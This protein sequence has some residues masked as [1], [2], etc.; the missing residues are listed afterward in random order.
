LTTHVTEPASKSAQLD[1]T[2]VGDATSVAESVPAQITQIG[3]LDP[4]LFGLVRARP[5]NKRPRFLKIGFFGDTGQ[6]KTYLYGTIEECIPKYVKQPLHIEI[7]GGALTI[8]NRKLIDSV[9]VTT[10][11]EFNQLFDEIWMMVYGREKW[12]AWVQAQLAKGKKVWLAKEYDCFCFDHLTELDKLIMKDI[13]EQTV[14]ED[15][16]RDPLVPAPREWGKGSER[17]RDVVREMRNMPVHC[18][19]VFLQFEK[20]D[21]ITGEDKIRPNV[22]GKL[23]GEIPG[24]LDI[25]GHLSV[26]TKHPK[27]KGADGKERSVEVRERVMRFQPGGRYLAKDRSDKLGLLMRNPTMLKI[28]DPILGDESYVP[29]MEE[30]LD[31]DASES[32]AQEEAEA[33]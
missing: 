7:E 6:G 3:M 9:T 13:M 17:L 32:E 12:W 26:E 21:P 22:H 8:A 2:Q 15:S 24:F 28:M 33:V 1:S 5:A 25:L 23:A 31:Y 14:K 27:V 10:W 16:K 30:P 11:K 19:F 29:V 18:V 4:S 20:E